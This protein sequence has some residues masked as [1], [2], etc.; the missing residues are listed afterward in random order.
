M[1][2]CLSVVCLF[3]CHLHIT[4][5]LCTNSRLCRFFCF[6]QTL[7]DIEL[8]IFAFFCHNYTK[9][10]TL[11]VEIQKIT[12]AMKTKQTFFH[13]GTHIP[14]QKKLTQFGT[15]S[16]ENAH[17]SKMKGKKAIEDEKYVSEISILL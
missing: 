8:I 1:V 14:P 2:N 15:N 7:L 12:K 16:I 4:K 5:I 6:P 11:R 17:F 3:N 10:F 9:G 13:F